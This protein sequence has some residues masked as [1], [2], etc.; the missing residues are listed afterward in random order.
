MSVEYKPARLR[1]V[2]GIQN[3]L[4]I[5][6]LSKERIIHRNRTQHAFRL[7]NSLD[8]FPFRSPIFC[9]GFIF[10]LRLY[11]RRARRISRWR[12]LERSTIHTE[13]ET[14][15]MDWRKLIPFSSLKKVVH[16]R[17]QVPDNPFEF[18][19]LKI[20]LPFLKNNTPEGCPSS[21][22]DIMD[23]LNVETVDCEALRLTDLEFVRTAFYDRSQFWLWR[24]YDNHGTDEAF[25][26][27]ELRGSSVL[28]YNT[29]DVTGYGD[30]GTPTRLTPEQ[31]IL[32]MHY[33][34]F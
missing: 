10:S 4:A 32:A 19:K 25:V 18:S 12:E 11:F 2:V 30:S 31:F 13:N 6:S 16:S 34:V 14:S 15:S 33:S 7:A 9:V 8:A 22:E 17:D 24:F 28:S 3:T 26:M 29:S 23:Y 27:V 21:M 20:E 1:L 5:Y